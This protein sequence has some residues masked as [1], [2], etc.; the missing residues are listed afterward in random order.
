MPLATRSGWTMLYVESITVPDARPQPHSCQRLS[1]RVA[2]TVGDKDS[3]YKAK[4]L[5]FYKLK[6]ILGP[7]Q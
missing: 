3:R 2:L 7:T 5:L 4:S 1:F 6:L